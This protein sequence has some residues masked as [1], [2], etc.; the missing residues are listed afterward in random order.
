VVRARVSTVANRPQRSVA[1]KCPQDRSG[2]AATTWPTRAL[3]R[4][5]ASG[6]AGPGP[7]K[8]DAG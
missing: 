5:T 8:H 6:S 7:V 2:A 3:G 1:A 4:S